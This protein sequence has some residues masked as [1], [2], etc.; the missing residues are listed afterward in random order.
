M[1]YWLP[2]WLYYLNLWDIFWLALYIVSYCLFESLAML[3]L[4]LLLCLVFPRRVIRDQFVASG[5]VIAGTLGIAAFLLQ[6]K[7]GLLLKIETEIFI[8]AP[9]VVVAVLVL[10][11]FVTAWLL[12]RIPVIARLI[13]TL[14][15][16]MTVF[17]YVYIPL[18]LL[19]AV[20]VLVRNLFL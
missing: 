12:R 18:G 14:A 16:R 11:I 6:R 2:S 20:L 1:F 3:G 8:L 17:L 19:G 7:I 9:V 5:S 15:E 4:M 10:Y 13:T